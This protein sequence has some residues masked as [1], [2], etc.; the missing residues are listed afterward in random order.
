MGGGE[1]AVHVER[2]W[3]GGETVRCRQ[4]GQCPQA[5]SVGSARGGASRLSCPI[6]MRRA[7]I[8]GRRER[9]R[10]HALRVG[11]PTRC[12][13]EHVVREDVSQP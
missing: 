13:D 9:E 5:L 2:G 1:G 10:P 11:V 3:L 6:G 7:A 8:D 4:W 12:D